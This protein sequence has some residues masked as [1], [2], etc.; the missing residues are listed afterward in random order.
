VVHLKAG[1]TLTV[2]NDGIDLITKAKLTTSAINPLV[3]L[4]AS[5]LTIGNGHLAL[6]R[7]GSFLNVGGDFLLMNSSTLNL[8][9][10]SFFM[11]QGGSFVKITGALVNFGTGGN[12]VNV[13]NNL[14]GSPC[15][16]I[17]GLNVFLTNGA[18]AGNVSIH[19]PITNAG[20]GTINLS[21]GATTAH[22]V[23]D[24][25]TTQV[26]IGVPPP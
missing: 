4:D 13:T 3:R 14:C 11:A 17:G 15:T 8:N 2:A 6:V 10:G 26:R 18:L 20:G 21:N 16:V 9:N 24:G 1:S 23:V 5:T 22:L 25:A 7:G 12:T 19:N